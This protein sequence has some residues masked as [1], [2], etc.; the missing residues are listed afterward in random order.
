MFFERR[1]FDVEK[2]IIWGCGEMGVKAYEI[3]S[4][5]GYDV[6]FFADNNPK[7]INTVLE[8]N[9]RKIRVLSKKEV[10]AS[11]A[12]I[13]I[14]T[15]EEY[16]LEILFQLLNEEHIELDRIRVFNPF[17]MIRHP[18]S[19]LY[20]F[21]NA[22]LEERYKKTIPVIGMEKFFAWANFS[23]IEL[24]ALTFIPGGS[25]VLDYAVI[26]TL[27]MKLRLKNY[28]EI[29]SFIGESINSASTV[30]EH[31]YSITM[32]PDTMKKY[33]ADMG[34]GNFANRLAYRDNI[35][36]YFVDSKEFDFSSVANKI[37]IYFIDGDH[38]YIGVYNDTKNIFAHKKKDAF[39]VWHDFRET[40]LKLRLSCIK[41]AEDAMGK[42][43]FSRMFL[44]DNCLCGIYVPESYTDIFKGL[45]GY[46]NQIMN[47]Y[48]VKISANPGLPASE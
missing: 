40:E 24:P 31:C 32:P 45:C 27:I 34:K 20:K 5:G 37:D 7:K 46:D 23:E 9:G 17:I 22:Q 29:G 36:Q 18:G 25:L 10:L 33:F 4:G 3:L 44:F 1:V 43:A 16:A 48:K 42:D 2:I 39:V 41:A 6:L 38:S 13:F 21:D 47:T 8:I 15:K 30:A 28:L 12:K 26:K 19:L 14:S 11:D 35:T